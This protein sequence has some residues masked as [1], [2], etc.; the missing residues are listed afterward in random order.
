MALAVKVT[1]DPAQIVGELTVTDG[2]CVT[3][4][5]ATTVFEQPFVVPV[6]VYEVVEAGETFIELIVDPVLQE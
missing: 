5:V 2:S 6:T 3:V 4:T 1:P